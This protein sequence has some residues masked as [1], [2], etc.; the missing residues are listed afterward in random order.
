MI[1]PEVSNYD[2]GI[3]LN[4]NLLVCTGGKERTIPELQELL[5]KVNF[6]ISQI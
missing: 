1:V 5:N 4:F 3:T 2:V 6:E